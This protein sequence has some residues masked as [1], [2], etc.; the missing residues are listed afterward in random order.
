MLNTSEWHRNFLAQHARE[1]FGRHLVSTTWSLYSPI[2]R[3]LLILGIL[4]ILSTYFTVIVSNLIFCA[5]KRH[6]LLWQEIIAKGVTTDILYF[7]NFQIGHLKFVMRT[8]SYDRTIPTQINIFVYT[9]LYLV[10]FR[11]K[12]YQRIYPQIGI[13]H[14]LFWQITDYTGSPI[15]DIW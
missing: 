3:F 7:Q 15:F 8:N 13:L 4:L 5:Q 2:Y 12:I 6:H 11:F 9:F 1:W 14:R 10:L